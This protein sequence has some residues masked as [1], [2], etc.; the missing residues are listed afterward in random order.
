RG[1]IR[2]KRSGVLSGLRV[3][4]EV[5]RQADD[6]LAFAPRAADG[7]AVEEGLV[8]A[9]VSGSVRSILLAERLALNFLQHLSGIATQTAAFVA[10]IRGTGVQIL[11]TRKT[12]PGMRLLEK[13]AV[14]HGGGA[15]HRMGLFDAVMIKDNH[16]VAVGG[17]ARA[18]EILSHA[19]PDVQVVLELRS[20][21]EIG[22]AVGS[23]VDR[24]LLDNFTP[25][26]I[27]RAVGI[28]RQ[29]ERETGRRIEIEV[30]GGVTL[31][32]VAAYAQPGVDFISIGSLTH[33]ARALDISLDLEREAHLR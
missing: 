6:G 2:V 13:C 8:V 10:R 27:T 32:T 28:L 33:S 12:T 1:L 21:S 17:I 4:Q 31:E 20:L 22:H 7:D 5:F 18:L 3:A 11:D 25:E 9:A 14:R 15:N 19:R 29:S 23:P 24:L 16:I 30:S 26:E